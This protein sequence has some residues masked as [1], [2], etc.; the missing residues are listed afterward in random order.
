MYGVRKGLSETVNKGTFASIKRWFLRHPGSGFCDF[1]DYILEH[2]KT[3]F[4]WV[5]EDPHISLLEVW[6]D[7]KRIEPFFD[8]NGREFAMDCILE[9][10]PKY[11]QMDWNTMLPIGTLDDPAGRGRN[12]KGI[13]RA[14]ARK[15]VRGN[16]KNDHRPIPCVCTDT[17]VEYRSFTQAAK[18]IGVNSRQIMDCC[19]GVRSDVKGYH[20]RLKVGE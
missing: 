20:F 16:V 6:M 10:Y 13:S 5:V 14:D 15:A 2:S 4:Y 17:G 1:M 19:Y 7:Y 18:D 3:M 11:F 12:S 9:H 8:E